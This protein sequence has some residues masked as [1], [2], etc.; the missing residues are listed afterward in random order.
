MFTKNIKTISILALV[1]VIVLVA[2]VLI[3]VVND[4]NINDDL[5]AKLEDTTKSYEQ[6]IAELNKIIEDLEAGLTDAETALKQLEENGIK[7]DSWIAATK[8]VAEKLEKLDEIVDE[9]YGKYENDELGVNIYDYFDEETIDEFNELYLDAYIAIIRAT[10]V[11]SMD[12]II[13]GI[14]TKIDGL[15]SVIDILDDKLTELEKDPITGDDRDAIFDAKDYFE[16]INDELLTENQKNN[17]ASRIDALIDAYNKVVVESFIAKVNALPTVAQLTG[18][19][20]HKAALQ[21]VSDIF[22]YIL[23]NNIDVEENEEFTTAGEKFSALLQ[24]SWE[25]DLIVEAANAVNAL[26]DA[27]ADTTFIADL[28]SAATIKALREA[29]KAWEEEYYIVT[30]TEADDYNEWIH[31]LVKYDTLAGYEKTFET[32]TAELKAAADKYIAAVNEFGKIGLDSEK[33]LDELLYLYK[34]LFGTLNPE[35]VDNILAVAKKEESVLSAWNQYLALRKSYDTLVETIEFINDTITAE[36]LSDVN[37]RLIDARIAFVMGT[38]ELD[39]TAFDEDGL[40]AYKTARLGEYVETALANALEAYET[41]D[42][43]LREQAYAALKKLIENDAA[44]AYTLTV[45]KVTYGMAI[46]NPDDL[47]YF[48]IID[49]TA[50]TSVVKSLSLYTLEY[51]QGFFAQFGA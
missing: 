6:K 30:D 25:I 23:L 37:F 44:G 34:D 46:D 20:E 32:A 11:D 50:T 33:G 7:L 31:N 42:N 10:S 8:V 35:D 16:N 36:D 15:K 3:A 51:C 48:F 29:V 1:A 41:S 4:S 5:N 19:D 43:V 22:A 24:R 18:S 2:S 49:N 47:G 21:E 28:E 12:E 45:K 39:E 26:I 17:F 27:E 9:F 38:Y 40:K 14:E 13:S